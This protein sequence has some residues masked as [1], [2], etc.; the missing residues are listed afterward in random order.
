VHSLPLSSVN[1][2]QIGAHAAGGAA[3][4]VEDF[5]GAIERA[6]RGRQVEV[7]TLYKTENSNFGF[8]VVGSLPEDR[9]DPGIYVRE[10]EP[11]KIAAK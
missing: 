2:P 7:I 5:P 10:I 1:S 8:G 3:G 11:N 9:S 6:S 4:H